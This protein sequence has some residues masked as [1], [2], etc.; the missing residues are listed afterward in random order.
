MNLHGD[1]DFETCVLG[2]YVSGSVTDVTLFIIY[3]VGKSLRVPLFE[4]LKF[5]KIVIYYET[6]QIL[7]GFHIAYI[8]TYLRSIKYP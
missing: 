6:G 1:S 3:L 7:E 5:K 4:I 2:P 8:W